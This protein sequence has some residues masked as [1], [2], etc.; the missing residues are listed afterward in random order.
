MHK[1]TVK[2]Y[3]G[4]GDSKTFAGE[5]EVDC[6]DTLEDATM[7]EGGDVKKVLSAYWSSKVIDIQRQIR[8]G[9]TVSAK[10]Q[11]NMLL[12][13]AKTDP[14]S[15]SLECSGRIVESGGAYV[16]RSD[17]LSDETAEVYV[18]GGMGVTIRR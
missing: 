16:K 17:E 3:N 7:L 6:P 8:S 2:A 9:T 14:C 10:A 1:V 12:A 4:S 5:R 11:L 15:P 13:K 18:I